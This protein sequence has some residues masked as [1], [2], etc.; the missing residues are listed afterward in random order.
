M[1]IK[2]GF[3]LIELLVV[4]GIMAVLAAGVVALINPLEKT[5]Q[6]NDANAQNGVGQVATA[7]Q[8]FAAQQTTG[9]YP[10][11]AQGLP[12]L[13]TTGE[14]VSMPAGVVMTY[15]GGGASAGVYAQLQSAKYIQG[16][17]AGAAAYWFW[18]SGNGRA[19]GACGGAPG[20]G[21]A[22]TF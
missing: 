19:C 17:C 6:A 21:T 11:A 12:Y 16:S 22:C 4:I 15:I 18:T 14:L 5:R 13:V 2:K 9:N 20:A 7:L 3:T 10:T 1:T 8:A